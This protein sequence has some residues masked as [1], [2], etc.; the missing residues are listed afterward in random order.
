VWRDEV[1]ALKATQRLVAVA[2]DTGAR[3]HVLHVST[4]EEME[5][6]AGH[7]DVASVETTPHHLTLEAPNCYERLGTRAQMNPPVRNAA[8]R[9]AIWNGIRNGVVDVLGS[10]HAPHTRE[11]KA[12]VYPASPSG[13]TGVQTLVPVMLDHVNAGRLSLLRF[14]DLTSAGPARLFGIAAKGRVAVGY[15]ADLTVVDLKRREIITDRWVASRAGWTPYNGVSV[16]GW[17]VGTLI[18]GHK[19]MWE[20]S[21]VT[22]AQ[23]ERVRFL[24]TLAS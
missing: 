20:G 21:L 4:L 18:R 11:E 12:K 3:V 23:G 10:D 16:I 13:M 14:V 15:D 1:V 17:P 24:E 6:L 9:S 22:R 7:K 5:F 2:H 19:V 8:H